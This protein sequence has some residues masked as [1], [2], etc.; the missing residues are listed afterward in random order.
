[1]KTCPQ[2]GRTYSDETLSFCLAD[3]ELLSAPFDPD[4]TLVMPDTKANQATVVIQNERGYLPILLSP[5][6]PEVFKEQLLR[7]R[8]AEIVT[9]Y[10]NGRVETKIWRAQNLRASS[11]VI[12]NLRSRPQFR[13]GQWQVRGIAKVTVKVLENA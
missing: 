13:A 11:N 12:G 10:A 9:T 7:T 5:S 1:M 3:G 6:D 2:C 4:A 8:V